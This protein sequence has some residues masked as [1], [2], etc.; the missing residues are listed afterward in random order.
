MSIS[1]TGSLDAPLVS[2]IIPVYNAEAYIAGSIQNVLNQTY[3]NIEIIVV[4]DGSTDQSLT[5]AKSFESNQVKVFSQTNKGASA[6]RNYGLKEAKGVFIQ[7][8]DADDLLSTNKIEEQVKL[9]IN[10]PQKLAICCSVHF[11]E[12]EDF[13]K[14]ELG[15]C[16]F[17]EESDD[18]IDF[19]I[20]LYGG[21]AINERYGGMIQPN[22]W[23]APMEIIRE[24]G[25][26]NEEI[27]VD[28]DGEFFCRVLLA[29]K[30]TRYAYNAV[31]YY[32]MHASGTNLSAQRSKKAM[33]SIFLSTQLKEKSL[34]AATTN[35]LA[36][37][38]I[39]RLY[40]DIA[41]SCYPSFYDLSKKAERKV[42]E[43]GGCSSQYYL[44][45][46]IYKIL[47]PLFGWKISALVAHYKN[48]LK[49][50]KF[51]SR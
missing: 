5:V 15:H 30:G 19:L 26:W 50:S 20:K 28:D 24:A 9:L 39:A 36:K 34:L 41:V 48:K 23:L 25:F 43:L 22:A 10:N 47:T 37:T 21:N 13:L 33:L 51:L 16:W 35:A 38:A 42:A 4:N 32:R 17:Q 29:S 6:A 11:L 27:T 1:E 45:T 31:N 2:V 3:P 7:F 8:L 12:G 14:K 18:P 44:H 49:A 46:P 40:L